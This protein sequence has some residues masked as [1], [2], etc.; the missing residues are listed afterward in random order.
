MTK[1]QIDRMRAFRERLKSENVQVGADAAPLRR[2]SLAECPASFAQHRLWLAQRLQPKS[3]FYNVTLVAS[4][5]GRVDLQ[6]LQ[7][8][9]EG[10]VQR[11][12]I[13]R[14]CFRARAGKPHQVIE[15]SVMPR[16]RIRHLHGEGLSDEE[17]LRRAVEEIGSEPFDLAATPLFRFHL[18]KRS[19]GESVVVFCFHHIIFDQQSEAVFLDELIRFYAALS[20][21]RPAA[22]EPLRFQYSDYSEH[23]RERLSG[24]RLSDLLRYWK[25]RVGQGESIPEV[26]LPFRRRTDDSFG[27]Q[28]RFVSGRLQARALQPLREL[29]LDRG[30]S[31]FALALTAFAIV[32]HKYT[33]SRDVLISFPVSN[34]DKLGLEKLVGFFVNL[35][36]LRTRLAEGSTVAEALNAVWTAYLEGLE[37]QEL[38]FEKL[39]E[40]ID[41]KRYHGTTLLSQNV[42]GFRRLGQSRLEVDSLRIE[43]REFATPHAKFEL[44]LLALERDESLDVTLEFNQ[45]CYREA[46]MGR[47]CANYLHLLERLPE[48]LHRSLEEVS[49]VCPQERRDQ[50]IAWNG[51]GSG[52]SRE[53]SILE[54]MEHVAQERPDSIAVQGVDGQ[55]S[56]AQLHRT[57]NRWARFLKRQGAGP[58]RLVGLCCE[59]SAGAIAALL[60]VLKSGGAYVA[61]DPQ[62]PPQRLKQII[63][64]TGLTLLLCTRDL[65]AALEAVGPTCRLIGL[66]TP[67]QAWDDLSPAAPNPHLEPENLAYVLMTSGSSG[68][69]KGVMVT[70]ANLLNSTLSRLEYYQERVERFLLLSP[71]YFDSS[72]AGL[73]WT[74]C[75]GGCLVLP[76]EGQ[77]RDVELMGAFIEADQISHLL[78]I[79]SLYGILIDELKGCRQLTLNTAIVAGE[80]CPADLAVRHSQAFESIRLYDEYGPTEGTVWN[81][82]SRLDGLE[83]EDPVAIG[84]PTGGLRTYLLDQRWQLL[85]AGAQGEIHIGGVGVA[86]GYWGRSAETAERFIPDGHGA[87]HG[88]RLYR[89]GDL[90]RWRGDGQLLYE[91][92][93]DDEVKIR[94]YRIALGEVESALRD[95]DEVNSAAVVVAKKGAQAQLIAFAVLKEG[96]RS[97]DEGLKNFLGERLPAPMKPSRIHLLS[98]LPQL[99][100]GKVDRKRLQTLEAEFEVVGAGAPAAKGPV[101]NLI[102]DAWSEVLGLEGVGLDDNFFEI[103]G[104]SLLATQVVSRIQTVFR[105]ALSLQNLFENPTVR[106]LAELI[107]GDD[108]P[109]RA[110]PAA[111]PIKPLAHRGEPLSLSLQQQRL[112]FLCETDPDNVDYILPRALRLKG[113]LDLESLQDA[114]GEIVRRHEAL[115]TSFFS[116][117]GRPMMRVNPAQEVVLAAEEVSPGP[118]QT[119]LEAVAASIGEEVRRP[120]DLARELIRMRLFRCGPEDHVLFFNMHHIISD[121]WS[122]GILISELEA[123]YNAF[124]KGESSPLPELALQYGDF[125]HWQRQWMQGEVLERY[126]DFWQEAL[127]GRPKSLPLPLKPGAPTRERHAGRSLHFESGIGDLEGL[128]ALC[129]ETG[130]TLFMALQ[131]VF[132][133]CLSWFSGSRDIVIGT[134][135]AGR[136]EASLEPLIG[137]FA[138]TMVLRL[139][140]EGDA[141]FRTVLGRARRF[142]LEAFALQEI[143]LDSLTARLREQGDACEGGIF[144]AFFVLHN[145]PIGDFKLNAL[146]SEFLDTP[147]P[148]TM[149]KLALSMAEKRSGLWYMLHY[150]SNYFDGETMEYMGKTIDRII[151][152]VV[153]EPQRPLFD[154]FSERLQVSLPSLL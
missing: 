52:A 106:E 85:P 15:E 62:S 97:S 5:L 51:A 71:L 14:T 148:T 50:L 91:G 84:R 66:E 150:D 4:L 130:T 73:Y 99:P 70:H 140:L 136:R 134:S 42:F 87:V 30:V 25:E 151:R 23:Q 21:G 93:S 33:G 90:G 122:L 95:H 102:A 103:G 126:L 75:Q 131:S 20:Q 59:R 9:L 34:R 107:K 141:D 48:I 129:R 109:S 3:P 18:L 39:V 100:N 110:R 143:P 124:S 10:I 116:F 80:A 16:L 40:S 49:A 7:G 6:A 74:L 76:Q 47:V 138:N 104:H 154:L 22:L 12:D 81:T 69:P 153:E 88:G 118:G 67:Q 128:R 82:V 127:R 117:E 54:R 72:V 89:S 28:G 137:F 26:H 105:N 43:P 58:D 149:F 55:L 60:G 53:V 19:E 17:G 121:G 147:N 44:S 132:A 27:F 29:A 79:P 139:S 41:P 108:D 115:R 96:A 133:A 65:K 92:R 119:A 83:S 152:A 32:L 24:E 98:A 114:I 77:Q 61:L 113:P 57:A 36:V 112:W 37:R 13:F 56:Y 86:R 123:L 144:D 145:E 64:D 63:Q 8:S 35:V 111:P 78:C 68:R 11:H 38:P 125:A 46:D 31:L 94:G 142:S 135:V 2:R 120:F 45:E 146:E 101:E 1:N